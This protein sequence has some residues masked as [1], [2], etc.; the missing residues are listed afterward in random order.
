M[1]ACIFVVQL[2][3]GRYVIGSSDNAAKRIARLNSGM[4]KEIPE[5]HQIQ[6]IV[7]IKEQKEGRTLIS[8]TNNFID[9]FGQSKV[10]VI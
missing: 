6:R 8:V 2:I 7:G 5:K 4:C 9:K 3:D 1:H 10:V